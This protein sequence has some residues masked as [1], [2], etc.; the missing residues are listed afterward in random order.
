MP[1][2]PAYTLEGGGS[3]LLIN[4]TLGRAVAPGFSPGLTAVHTHIAHTHTAP[5]SSHT[6]LTLTHTYTHTAP[7]PSHTALTLTHT[8]STQ[9]H[10]PVLIMHTLLLP[11]YIHTLHTPTQPHTHHTLLLPSPTANTTSSHSINTAPPPH[12]HNQHTSNREHISTL[13]TNC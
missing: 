1:R 5:H 7:Y 8:P 9:P 4:G 13:I 3:I 12:A 2:I 11:S 6:A 10:N